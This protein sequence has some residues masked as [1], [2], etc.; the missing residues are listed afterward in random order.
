MYAYT[1]PQWVLFFLF[2]CLAG[3]CIESIFV[4]VRTRRLVN[5]GFL[6]GPAIPIYGFGAIAILFATL[7][8]RVRP[9]LVFLLGLAAATVRE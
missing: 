4:S 3:W 9:A 5:R 7:P 8:V 2:Y 6:Y 1:A